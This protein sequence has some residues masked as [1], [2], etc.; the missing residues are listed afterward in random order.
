MTGWKMSG[1]KRNSEKFIIS[2]IFLD[3]AANRL[4]LRELGNVHVSL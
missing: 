2:Q 4:L 1:V 3:S